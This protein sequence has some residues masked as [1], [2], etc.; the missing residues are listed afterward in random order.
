MLRHEAYCSAL[1]GVPSICTCGAIMRA[2]VTGPPSARGL[3]RHTE[4]PPRGG[5]EIISFAAHFE[6]RRRARIGGRGA[7]LMAVLARLG[8]DR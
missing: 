6:A 8:D 1:T 2:V 5:A 4:P 7:R 3:E